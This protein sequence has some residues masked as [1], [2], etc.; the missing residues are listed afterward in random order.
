MEKPGNDSSKD[1]RDKW[2]TI[3]RLCDAYE[4]SLQEGRVERAPFFV[5]IPTNWRD[6]LSQEFDAIDAAYQDAGDTC[7]RTVQEGALQDPSSRRL[8]KPNLTNNL[9]RPAQKSSW[10]GRFEVKE[11]LGSGATGSVWRARR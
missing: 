1:S 2:V 4:A 3:D 9:P 8:P 6:Q 7:K 11:R 5:G 10:L